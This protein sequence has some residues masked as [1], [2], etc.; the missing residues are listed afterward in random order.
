MKVT[1]NQNNYWGVFLLF[2]LITNV[3]AECLEMSYQLNS[4]I[5]E[6][7]VTIEINQA[8]NDVSSFAFIVEYDQRIIMYHP[9]KMFDRGLLLKNRF[10]EFEVS[11]PSP[12]QLII[13][14]FEPG[15]GIIHLK[16]SGSLVKLTFKILECGY[17]EIIVRDLK[18]DFENWSVNSCIINCDN[19]GSISGKII[20]DITGQISSI[21][22]A[23][24]LLSSTTS[25]YSMQT[26][27]TLEGLFFFNHIP[28]D[29]YRLEVQALK[30][31]KQ[32]LYS[33][34]IENEQDVILKPLQLE[35][36]S[37][38]GIYTQEEFDQAVQAIIEK[39]DTNGDHRFG[40]EEIIAGL[41]LLSGIQ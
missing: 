16:E 24:V 32:T 10:S 3:Q 30:F 33:I 6:I 34:S 2:L 8:P 12:G 31:D 26:K 14:G 39:Y 17:H 20:T 25:A 5:N 40:L 29:I 13:G 4:T 11:N 1:S 7:V 15:S 19:K 41:Q 37:C 18:D 9:E 23:Q 22:N 38:E 36:M 21:S 27:T 35:I 28:N